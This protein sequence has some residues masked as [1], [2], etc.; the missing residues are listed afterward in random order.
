MLLP[1]QW[2]AEAGERLGAC[3]PSGN[4]ASPHPHPSAGDPCRLSPKA[5]DAGVGGV[6]LGR[7]RPSRESA[8]GTLAGWEGGPLI[9]AGDVPEGGVWPPGE[10]VHF[11]PTSRV[12]GPDPDSPADQQQGNMP[13]DGQPQQSPGPG[14]LSGAREPGTQQ[15]GPT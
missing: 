7:Q 14:S 10:V 6:W 8:R 13:E 3:G 15:L 1:L 11:D 5:C 9:A 4:G 2:E 12:S